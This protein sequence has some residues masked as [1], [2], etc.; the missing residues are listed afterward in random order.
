MSQICLFIK[1][2]NLSAETV[3]RHLF[4]RPANRSFTPTKGFFTSR[5]AARVVGRGATPG[6]I[7][8]RLRRAKNAAM[9]IN[10]RSLVAVGLLDVLDHAD[11]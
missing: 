11:Q 7:D 9:R 5:R 2:W 10:N 1:T 8:R 4:S 6:L 3:G